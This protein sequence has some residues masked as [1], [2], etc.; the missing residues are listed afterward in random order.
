MPR[1]VQVPA[2]E[3]ITWTNT[4][5][6]PHAISVR[7]QPWTTGPIAPGATGSIRFDTPGRYVYTCAEHPWHQGEITVVR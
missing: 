4:G 5:D 6:A 3:Q 1:R 2:G 7:Q